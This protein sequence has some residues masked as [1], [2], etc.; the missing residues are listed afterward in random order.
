MLA[1]YAD[2]SGSFSVRDPAQPWV[3][4]LAIG[5]D[6]DHWGT[7]ERALNDLK[8]RHFPGCHPS[9]VEIRSNDLRRAHVTGKLGNVFSSLKP[10]ALARFASDLYATVDTLPFEWCAAAVHK[11]SALRDFG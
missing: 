10:G 2:E 11:P 1:F 3:V 8:R 6:D 5:F 9:A 4:L 7:I